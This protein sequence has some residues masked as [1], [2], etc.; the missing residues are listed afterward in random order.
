MSVDDV[1]ESVGCSIETNRCGTNTDAVQAPFPNA[2]GGEA[3]HHLP[4]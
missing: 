4:E 3:C 2:F 1:G